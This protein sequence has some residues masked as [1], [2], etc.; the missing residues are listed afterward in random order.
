MKTISNFRLSWLAILSLGLGAPIAS[1]Q[2]TWTYDFRNENNPEVGAVYPYY[3]TNDWTNNR[4]P[5]NPYWEGGFLQM[6]G[7]RSHGFVDSTDPHA[8]ALAIPGRAGQNGSSTGVYKSNSYDLAAGLKMIM[9]WCPNPGNLVDDGFY[10]DNEIM[11]MGLVGSTTSILGIDPSL[12]LSLVEYTASNDTNITNSLLAVR[13]EGGILD[14]FNGGNGYD[15]DVDNYYMFEIDFSLFEGDPRFVTMGLTM[16]IYNETFF[17]S[18]SYILSS[19]VD[20]GS[21]TVANPLAGDASLYP[22]LGITLRDATKV[23]ISGAN[24]DTMAVIPE[25]GSIALLLISATAA[26]AVRRRR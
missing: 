10:A 7:V 5:S 1:A 24:F 3:S 6:S 15:F 19:T 26:M 21:I 13:T 11:Q 12:F 20:F 22:A 23:S 4:S 14:Y 25:P 16:D 18:H 8:W 9:G 2:S 17:T